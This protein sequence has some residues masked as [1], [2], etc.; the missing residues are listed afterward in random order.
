MGKV[1]LVI[2]LVVG[3]LIAYV[4]S[5]PMW[6]DAGVTAA[7]IFL[8]CGVLGA[9]GPDRPWLWALAVGAWVPVFGVAVAGNYG[10]LLAVA[11]AF[12]GSY[13]GMGL[14]RLGALLATESSPGRAE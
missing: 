2:A 9:A 5:R 10:S 8:C 6:D 3:G 11:F 12:A 13:A 7:A 4:D 14:R 1:L